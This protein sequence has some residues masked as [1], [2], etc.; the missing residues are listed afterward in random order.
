MD[1]PLDLLRS[2]FTTLDR[3]HLPYLVGGSFATSIF[4]NRRSTN[5]LDLVLEISEF[6]IDDFVS[7][8]SGEFMVSRASIADA[9]A[10]DDP[11]SGF[12][13][14]HT[15]KLFRIDVFIRQYEEFNNIEFDTAREVEIVP[16]I[17]SPVC[18]PECIVLRK[19]MWFEMGGRVSDRQFNDVVGV[20]EVQK[21]RLDE[22][23]MRSW[24]TRLGV[25]ESLGL[26]LSDVAV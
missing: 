18:S 5:D 19:L 7:S 2:V 25:A 1:E 12:Q 10:S 23:F 20:L 13:I 4:G 21:G 6:D 22:P 17:L 8:F 14:T 11:Y 15:E 9:I 16:G 3:L 24:A 26:A